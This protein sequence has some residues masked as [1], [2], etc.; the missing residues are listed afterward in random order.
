M[1][2]EFVPSEKRDELAA[3]EKNILR[4]HEES[5]IHLRK[6]IDKAGGD[7]TRFTDDEVRELEGRMIDHWCDTMDRITADRN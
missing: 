1:N 7:N 6:M 5:L 2:L 4:A 3:I